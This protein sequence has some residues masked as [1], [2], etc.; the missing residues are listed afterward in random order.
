ARRACQWSLLL[1]SQR[2]REWMWVAASTL[3][4]KEAAMSSTQ[5]A[6]AAVEAA[7]ALLTDAPSFPRASNG[8]IVEILGCVAELSRVT[9]ALQVRLAHEVEERSQGPTDEPL[10]L[11]LG[12]RHAKEAVGRAFGV[13]PGRA[14]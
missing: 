12:A 11:V 6:R 4:P 10:S 8:E 7:R 9:D 2:G 13:R 3:L 5:Q 14:L 1:C